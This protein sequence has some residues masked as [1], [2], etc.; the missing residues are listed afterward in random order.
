MNFLEKQ[1]FKFLI[2]KK[3]IEKGTSEQIATKEK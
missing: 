1:T 2:K 3:R